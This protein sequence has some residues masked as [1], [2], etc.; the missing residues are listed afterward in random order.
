MP[1]LPSAITIHKPQQIA[2]VLPHLALGQ[3]TEGTSLYGTMFT[4]LTSNGYVY[5]DGGVTSDA[6]GNIYGGNYFQG[7]GNVTNGDWTV[8]VPAGGKGA[9]IYKLNTTLGVTW[10]RAPGGTATFIDVNSVALDPSDTTLFVVGAFV[11]GTLTYDNVTLTAPVGTSNTH[12]FLLALDTVTGDPRWGQS[13]TGTGNNG[14]YGVGVDSAGNIIMNGRT[15]NGNF[16]VNGVTYNAGAFQSES[17]SMK[18]S[19]QQW[20]PYAPHEDI[21]HPNVPSIS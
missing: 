21:D 15:H 17:W 5:N 18:V 8:A 3:T 9:F 20:H 6:H 4:S 12:A 13:W 1:A 2:S 11:G 7:T 14:P 10:L 16:V 19:E